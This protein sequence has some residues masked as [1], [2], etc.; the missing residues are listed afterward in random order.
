MIIFI[1]EEQAYRS[2]LA[3]HRNGFVVDWLQKPTRKPPVVHRA[4]C[5]EI[6]ISPSKQTH[7]TT[8]R[9]LKACGLEL[10]ELIAWA[11]EESGKEVLQCASC[12]ADQETP[13][14]ASAGTAEDH[15]HLTSLGR[16]IVD[17]VLE[18]A[19]MCLDGTTTE[20][21]VTV[22]DV[23]QCLSK[24]PAQLTAAIVRLT[25]DDYIVLEPPLVPGATLLSRTQI[26]PTDK[27]LRTIPAFQGLSASEMTAELAR[28][29]RE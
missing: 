3:H 4:T 11:R 23:A 14:E 22:G 6:R 15:D 18:I 25:E 19:V 24:T 21:S 29:Q 9:H 5:T 7:R 27:A 13:G 17:Y 16:A 1:H 2:W 28:L 8:G 20:Y 10:A 12:R 26:L